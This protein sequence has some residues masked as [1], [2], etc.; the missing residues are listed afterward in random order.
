MSARPD[1]QPGKSK[2]SGS[3][4][5]LD[6]RTTDALEAKDAGSSL[7]NSVDLCHPRILFDKYWDHMK[8]LLVQA[9]ES[10]G[11]TL[12]T[13]ALGM[14][15]ATL[16]LSPEDVVEEIRRKLGLEEKG[17]RENLRLA[18]M[19]ASGL[20]GS[21]LEEV[22][23]RVG[24]GKARVQEIQAL[25]KNLKVVKRLRTGNRVV[26]LDNLH[27]ALL[28]VDRVRIAARAKELVT[29]AKAEANLKAKKK[30]STQKKGK[31]KKI[32]KKQGSSDGE[33]SDSESS[34]GAQDLVELK[35]AGPGRE[36]GH[37]SEHT[38]VGSEAVVEQF[39]SFRI[40]MNA[41]LPAM[42]A[43]ARAQT[44]LA[45][46]P[47]LLG[48]VDLTL[49][50][51]QVAHDFEVADPRVP[52][53]LW[54]SFMNELKAET[55][56]RQKERAVQRR[57]T[58]ANERDNR[59]KRQKVQSRE[60]VLMNESMEAERAL[61]LG[62]SQ[63]REYELWEQAKATAASEDIRARGRVRRQQ[64]QFIPMSMYY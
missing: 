49:C 35:E 45:V 62:V 29:E 2:P 46:L 23:R 6:E 16:R 42:N 64:K 54:L 50:K 36:C 26:L 48:Q 19:T 3:Y 57:A 34:M 15:V 4:A 43:F 5:P 30:V 14:L 20:L 59:R 27:S 13:D 18:E 52:L 63:D 33:M 31:G 37:M 60:K 21:L 7:D 53:D 41:T 38:E 44:T 10:T 39:V 55:V 56:A 9:D 8:T 40:A 24:N 32:K 61:G 25:L 1:L 17:R 51:T 28:D 11:K 58:Q 47:N 22:L 12:P